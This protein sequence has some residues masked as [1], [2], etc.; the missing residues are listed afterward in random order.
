[1]KPFEIAVLG[2]LPG[3]K[4]GER[5]ADICG[6]MG[7][8]EASFYTWKK[9][10]AGMGI[11]KLAE[12]R[13][14]RDEN[15]K[16]KRL[17]ADLS[18]D[19]HI[20]QEIVTKS[21][22]ARQLAQWTQ[23]SSQVSERRAARLLELDRATLRYR[24][25]KD[26]QEGLRHRLRELAANRVRYGYRRLTV[27]L[28]RECWKVNAKRI[29]RI[30]SEK[31]LTARTPERKNLASR[32]RVPLPAAVRPNQRWSMDFMAAR[33][34]DNR[35]FR[36]LTVIDQYT[37]ECVALIADQRMNG[38]KVSIAAEPSDRRTRGDAGDDHCR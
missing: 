13:Q 20:L 33:L 21:S 15:S 34:H 22:E 1:M 27:L 38:G 5:V 37:R 18:L 9:Q 17:V 28:Q 25:Y 31:G 36:I 16:L 10:Y 19:R 24:S 8:S 29:Y 14:L 30:Y 7:I 2:W 26:R 4:G 35:L 6:K 32:T 23:R 11:A 12:L 3:V